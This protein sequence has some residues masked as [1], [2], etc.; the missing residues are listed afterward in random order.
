MP[1]VC[2]ALPC[3]DLPEL[4]PEIA[5]LETSARDEFRETIMRHEIMWLPDRF[6]Q[7]R[8]SLQKLNSAPALQFWFQ[9]LFKRT[10]G[11]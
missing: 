8:A 4:F 3:F 1:P 7:Y 9:E 10:Y 6:R 11:V 2:T 5:L